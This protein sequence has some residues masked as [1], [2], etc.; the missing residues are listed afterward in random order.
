MGTAPAFIAGRVMK[1]VARNPAMRRMMVGGGDI[2][3]AVGYPLLVAAEARRLG[4]ECPRLFE[5]EPALR[6]LAGAQENGKK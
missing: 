5:I 1:K 6:A 4:V 3:R 2:G